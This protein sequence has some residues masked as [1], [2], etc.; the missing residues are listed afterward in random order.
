MKRFLATGATA[1]TLALAATPGDAAQCG[2][3][4]G[5]FETWKRASPRKRAGRLAPPA[6]TR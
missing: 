4:P 2:N 3:G 5:G 6:S 1:L